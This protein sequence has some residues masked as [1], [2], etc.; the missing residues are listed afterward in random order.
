MKRNAEHPLVE[1]RKTIESRQKK[2]STCLAKF[3]DEQAKAMPTI[4]GRSQSKPKNVEDTIL[5]LPSDFTATERLELKLEPLAHEEKLLREGELVDALAEVRDTAQ[6]LTC[7]RTRKQKHARHQRQN[8]RTLSQVLEAE[9][10]RNAAIEDYNAARVQLLR[11]VDEDPRFPPLTI[12]DTFRKSTELKRQ[13][14]D[15]RRGEGKIWSV[16]TSARARAN[17]TASVDVDK[18]APVEEP[19][20]EESDGEE[21]DDEEPDDEETDEETGD[22]QE[23][24]K[25]V[26]RDE[27]KAND[28]PSSSST[29]K[30]LRCWSLFLYVA[31]TLIFIKAAGTVMATRKSSSHSTRGKKKQLSPPAADGDEPE[32]EEFSSKETHGWIWNVYQSK[33]M[34]ENEITAWQLDS[35]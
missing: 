1:M 14:G 31:L 13:V 5:H 22:E 2:L 15:S 26:E 24:V 29:L 21:P 34:T 28:L 7:A 3:F 18:E 10:E 20:V 23:E 19:A 33:G 32:L 12:K 9:N 35:E 11:L 27:A 6:H 8:T 4:T 30:G 25:V 17:A 16:G